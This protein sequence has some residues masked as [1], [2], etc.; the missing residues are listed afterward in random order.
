MSNQASNGYQPDY[1]VTPGE[2]LE[3]ELELRRMGKMELAKCTGLTERHIKA[4]VKEKSG[5]TPETAIK[6]ERAL[7]MS[8]EYWLNLETHYQEARARL[9]KEAKLEGARPGGGAGP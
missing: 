4:I 3:Y 2:V 1:V 5:I 6:L 8:A 9:G 7:G